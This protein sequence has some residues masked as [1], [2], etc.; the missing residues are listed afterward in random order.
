MRR[1]LAAV[2]VIALLL[3]PVASLA[4]DSAIQPP[5]GSHAI[6]QPHHRLTGW[7]LFAALWLDWSLARAVM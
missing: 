6:S 1:F 2:A 5:I 7:D 4:D 3:V